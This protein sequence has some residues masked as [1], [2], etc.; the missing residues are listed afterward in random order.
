MYSFEH[1]DAYDILTAVTLLSEPGTEAVA[2]GTDLLGE[3]KRRIRRPRR[4]VNLKAIAGLKGIRDAGDLSIGALVTLGEIEHEPVVLERLPALAEAVASAATPQLRNMGTLAGNLCQRPRCWY[5]R[6]PLF[7][8]WLKGGEKCFAVDGENRYHA[9]LGGGICH[10]VHPSDL[11]PALVALDAMVKIVGRA[12]DRE[13][14]LEDFYRIPT[15]DHRK[16]TVLEADELIAEIRVALPPM[17]SR[18]VYLKVME[19]RAWSFAL[20][21]LAAHLRFEGGR[22]AAVRL[23]L[24]G[25]APIPWRLKEAEEMLIGEKWSETVLDPVGEIILAQARPL[26]DNE[27]KIQLLRGVLREAARKTRPVIGSS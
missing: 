24:G 5:Y 26:R 3:L 2:G 22:I 12:G 19:R 14:R 18:G 11:A 25:V 13:I 16:T 10:A 20:V 17:D 1:I 15:Q 6:S 7:H 8:C 27:F 4:L 9:I 21:A 23:V